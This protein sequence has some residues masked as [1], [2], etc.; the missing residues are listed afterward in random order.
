VK[1]ENKFFLHFL[2]GKI[3]GHL[4]K[5]IYGIYAEVYFISW[6]ASTFP[7]SRPLLLSPILDLTLHDLSKNCDLISKETM[8][9]HA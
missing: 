3:G 4:Y 8:V 7:Q 9:C 5:G 2:I 6:T 1:K